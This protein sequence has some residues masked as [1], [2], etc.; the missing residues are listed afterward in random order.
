MRKIVYYVHV[1]VDGH[2]EGPNGEFDWA[3]MGPELSDYSDELCERT[4]TFL[5][6]R[7]VWGV[8]SSYWPNAES[9]SDHPHDLK[10]APIWRARPKVVVS[11][12]LEKVEWDAQLIRENV[13]EEI[14]ALKARPGKDILLTGGSKL[15]SSLTGLGLVDEWHIVVHPIVLGGGQQLFPQPQDRLGLRLA[16][17]RV[18]DSQAVLLR[19]EPAVS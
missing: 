11:S 2:I 10:F 1:S 3:A 4:D 7:T 19:Y 5:Y 15:M 17:T 16:E 14:T 18:L 8:M 13:A 6:G 12:T 9:I